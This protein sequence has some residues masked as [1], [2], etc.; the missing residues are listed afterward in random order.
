MRPHLE[1]LYRLAYRLTGAGAD[2]EDLLQGVLCNLY[3]RRAELSTIG[4]L[5]PWLQSVLYHR[6]VERA[7][8]RR[9]PQSSVPPSGSSDV[10]DLEAALARL[11]PEQ[12]SVLMLHDAEGLELGE[13]REIAGV[14]LDALRSRLE[15]A[16]ARLH[17][18]LGQSAA[19]RQPHEGDRTLRAAL[20]QLPVPLPAPGFYERALQA[21]AAPAPR[22]GSRV[23]AFGFLGA[24]GLTVLTVL[25]TG[26]WVRAPRAPA[27]AAPPDQG[28]DV[29]LEIDRPRTVNL[30]FDSRAALDDVTL[31]VAL[32]P[33]VELEGYVGRGSV[34]WTTRL[35]AGNNL[36]PLEIVATT[37]RGG[38]LVAR[39]T[40]GG[41]EK[42]FVVNISV[43]PR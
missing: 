21:A 5:G 12:R 26:L 28:Y 30:L 22:R 34:E 10:T 1:T 33:G 4:S 18:L 31:L 43:G 35:R 2:S 16:R 36:L 6:F 40:H 29:Q 32:P 15:D 9:A 14:E 41:R 42:T 38:S 17:E 27:T 7:R 39:L 19:D 37:A 13:I 23:V 3:E 25:F 20:A 8:W 24:F 11:T